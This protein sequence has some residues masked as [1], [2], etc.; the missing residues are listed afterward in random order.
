[1]P[2]TFTTGYDEQRFQANT[3][4]LVVNEYDNFT[5]N[6]L[7]VKGQQAYHD[8]THGTQLHCIVVQIKGYDT[9]RMLSVEC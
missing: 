8:L 2:Q 6:V 4:Y 7:N 1:M 5:N 9:M 3:L